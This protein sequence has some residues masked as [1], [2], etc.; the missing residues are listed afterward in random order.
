M[1][2]VVVGLGQFGFA[3]ASLFARSG[4]DTIAIDIEMSVVERIKDEVSLAICADATSLENLVAHDVGDADVLIAAIGQD[5]E[6][7][8]MVVVHATKLGIPRIVARSASDAH[9]R[10]LKAIGTHEVVNPE[11]EAAGTMVQRLL[12]PDKGS[13]RLSSLLSAVEMDLPKGLA[14]R[15]LGDHREDLLERYEV[16]LFAV[17]RA[18]EGGE[19]L[20]VRSSTRLLEGDRL[21]LAGTATNLSRVLHGDAEA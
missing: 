21:H 11:R 2:A 19:E 9:V 17:E 20:F 8:V 3:A 1:K 13:R 10:V 5:F 18:G 16:A 12:S 7:L 14:G 4:V 15:T 6:A